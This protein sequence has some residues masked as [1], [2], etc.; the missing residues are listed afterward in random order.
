MAGYILSRTILKEQSIIGDEEEAM[1]LD[2]ETRRNPHSIV[3]YLHVLCSSCK[4]LS[5]WKDITHN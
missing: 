3:F 5:T 1:M 2:E 4:Y